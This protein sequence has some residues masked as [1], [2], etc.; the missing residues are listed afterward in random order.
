MD[1]SQLSKEE[2]ER[3]AAK[4]FMKAA[5][6]L[7]GHNEKLAAEL[8]KANEGFSSIINDERNK[9]KAE[10]IQAVK[11]ANKIL[12]ELKSGGDLNKALEKLNALKI[13]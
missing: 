5:Q 1:Y 3:L 12:K 9:H 11:A 8:K 13:K 10:T 2:Q 7:Q 4:N 6:N